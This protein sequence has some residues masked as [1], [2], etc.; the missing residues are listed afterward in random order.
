MW[1]LGESGESGNLKQQKF[2]LGLTDKEKHR[3]NTSQ[4]I[5]RSFCTEFLSC[6]KYC[7]TLEP[8]LL[9][10]SSKGARVL[11]NIVVLIIINFIIITIWTNKAFCK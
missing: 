9:S 2:Q 5:K 7:D 6:S 3:I 11:S 1:G 8:G 4:A 10:D